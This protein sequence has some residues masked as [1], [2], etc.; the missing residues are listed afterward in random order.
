M[1]RLD[2]A[3]SSSL[4]KGIDSCSLVVKHGCCCFFC[5]RLIAT[6]VVVLRGAPARLL[7]FPYCLLRISTEAYRIRRCCSCSNV[8]CFFR[9]QQHEHHRRKQTPFLSL[10]LSLSLCAVPWCRWLLLLLLL[11]QYMRSAFFERNATGMPTAARMMYIY[12]VLESVESFPEEP[13]ATG[14]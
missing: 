7:L 4:P 14:R 10:Y 6:G 8:C 5:C 2:Q 9:I 12:H 3:F 1:S 11:Q 13:S